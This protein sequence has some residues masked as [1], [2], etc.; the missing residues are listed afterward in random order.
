[1]S[2]S[3]SF[4]RSAFFLVSWLAFA[5]LAGNAQARLII[6]NDA[7]LRIDNGAWVVL[8][9][10]APTALQTMGTGGNVRSEGEFN[11]IRWQIRNNSGVYTVPFTTAN[12][13]KMPFT[14]EVV[15]PGSDDPTASICFSTFNY[16]TVAANNW[17]NFNYKPSDVF[18][19]FSYMDLVQTATQVNNS[20][21]VVDRFWEVDAGA[22]GYAYTTKP[23]VRLGFTY[24][25]SSGTGDVRV[26]NTI[27]GSSVVGAQR[28]NSP[29]HLWG[30]YW[31]AGTWASG[32]PVNSVTNVN[33]SAADFFRSWTLSDITHPLPVELVRFDVKCDQGRA[34]LSWSTGSETG[35]DRFEV[36]RSLDGSSFEVIGVVRAAGNSQSAI[37]YRFV[38]ERPMGTAY[39]RLRQVDL[40]GRTAA[41]SELRPAACD[42]NSGTYIVNAWDSGDDLM[43]VVEADGDQEHMVRL[44]DAAGK[45]VWNANNVPLT[46][47]MNTLRIPQYDLPLGIYSIRFD[48]AG[49]AMTRRVAL[50]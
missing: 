38:D 14:Y 35:S 37:D 29:A 26:S 27:T 8:E 5:P 22:S 10:P 21:Y 49:T 19:M 18:H 50:Y 44:F 9:N 45:E 47:G 33:V 24:D 7:W 46:E 16:G 43:V 13:V 4:P 40:N 6:N 28:Y 12:G 20:D 34:L 42:A 25:P 32:T 23:D 15:V 1:M 2:L 17:N 41:Y 30:D 31:P 3:P 36:E 11:R 48:G 39:Y